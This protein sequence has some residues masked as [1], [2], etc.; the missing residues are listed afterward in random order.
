MFVLLFSGCPAAH[1]P[2]LFSL[3]GKDRV[4]GEGTMGV[5][6]EVANA[7]TE[8]ERERRKEG[9][10]SM[11]EEDTT[12]AIHSGFTQQMRGEEFSHREQKKE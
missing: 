12:A 2:F 7:E 4:R 10:E 1:F 5:G 3:L 6:A 9:L 8:R 11:T